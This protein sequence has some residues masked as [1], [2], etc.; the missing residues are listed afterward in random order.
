MADGAVSTRYDARQT[1]EAWYSRWE[2][3]GLFLPGPDDGKP[4]YTITIPPPNVTGSLHMGHAL[5]YGLQDMLARFKRM[6]GHQVLVLP[7]QD[8]AGI[9]TQSLVEKALRAEGTSRVELGREKFL[10]R[11]WKFREESGGTILSQLRRLGCSFD[12]SRSRFTLDEKYHAAVLHVF[13]DWFERGL[14]YRGRRVVNWDPA[15]RTSVSDIETERV[16]KKGSLYHVRYPFAD[17]SGAVVVATTRPETM[18]GD[19][20]VAVHPDDARYQ[21]LVGKALRHPLV[22]REIPLIADPFPDPG[23]GT[24]AVKITPG[25]DADDFEVGQRHGLEVLV[26]LDEGARVV[27]GYGGYSG[28]DRTEARRQIVLDLEASGA[29]VATEPHEIALVVS[30][31]SHEPV[32]PMASEQWF[33]RQSLLAGPAAEAVRDGRIRFVPERFAS[34]YLD[35]LDNIR[36]WCVSRQLWWGHRIPV[37]YTQ[38]GRAIAATSWDEAQAK[39]GGDTIVRQDEDVLDTWFSSGLWPF[40][41]LGWPEDSPELRRRYPTSVLV[42]ARDILYLWVARMAMMGLDQMGEVPFRDVFIYATVLTEDGKRMSKSL[43]TGVDPMDVVEEKGADALRWTL[44]SQTGDNQELRYSDRKTTDARNLAN[45]VWNATRFVAGSLE[46]FTKRLDLPLQPEDRWILGRLAKTESEVR[47]GYEEYEP[48]RVCSALYQFFWS[49][50][51][52]W[53]IEIAKPRLTDP[54][55][56]NAPQWVLT[57][58]LRTFYAMLHPVMPH[59]TEAA[60]QVL[61]P[62]RPMVALSAWPTPDPAWHDVGTEAQVERWFGLVRAVRAMRAELGVG[63][64]AKLSTIWIEGDLAGGEAVLAGQAWF[65][66]W[67]AGRPRGRH[68]S[69]SSSGVDAHLEVGEWLDEEREAARLR[70]RLASL[71]AEAAALRARLSRPDFVERAKPEVV[72]RERTALAEREQEVEKARSWLSVLGG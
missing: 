40:A 4:V 53:Y 18:L 15:L 7:G 2:E 6:T 60:A 48:Q 19:V 39:A 12:W 5:C 41:T 32:E 37:Y 1:E 62:G 52:D 23:F 17:G 3:A 72:Q 31:R 9:A 29:L 27:E 20:A 8:H 43:G 69:V 51:C 22:D 47:A 36:D 66:R 38:D 44:F 35:W 59:V 30:S 33:V 56:R 10:E 45:K 21:G 16:A 46:G 50:L 24:G 13:V 70:K 58:A 49:E 68:V 55:Q 26:V 57:E 67:Q 42:T 61:E 34:V 71:E 14:V 63:P 65:E 25:H 64:G 28:L 11:V 54:G